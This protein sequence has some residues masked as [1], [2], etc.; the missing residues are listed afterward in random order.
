M[1]GICTLW[2]AHVCPHSLGNVQTR[3]HMYSLAPTVNARH[4]DKREPSPYSGAGPPQTHSPGPRCAHARTPVQRSG[5]SPVADTSASGGRPRRLLGNARAPT[6]SG[7]GPTPCPAPLARP[8][9]LTDA[10]GTLGGGRSA[11]RTRVGGATAA[12]SPPG[13][14]ASSARA[15]TPAPPR[16][17]TAPPPAPV[18]AAATQAKGA[19]GARSQPW[20]LIVRPRW[21]DGGP[22]SRSWPLN[23]STRALD[24]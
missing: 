23:P 12:A 13:S 20:R 8:R 5:R 16:R 4:T 3:G 11:G 9:P 10:G 1:Y 14:A 6:A 24:F 7:D 18:R 15:R 17:G 22:D 21:G 19:P 2:P